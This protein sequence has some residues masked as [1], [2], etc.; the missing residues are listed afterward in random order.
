M[1]FM[2]SCKRSLCFKI[3]EKVVNEIHV[4]MDVQFEDITN[5][6]TRD[7]IQ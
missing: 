4:S 5:L 6:K 3:L 1:G 2:A 7:A